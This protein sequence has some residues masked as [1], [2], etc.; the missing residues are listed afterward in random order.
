MKGFEAMEIETIVVDGMEI[1]WF[2]EFS[3]AIVET[4]REDGS[5]PDDYWGDSQLATDWA[6]LT[7]E[8]E[9]ATPVALPINVDIK[10]GSWPNPINPKETGVFSVA[11]CG[12]SDFDITTVNPDEITIG[13]PG[14]KEGV[15]P[16]RW[17]YNDTATPWLGEDGMGHELESDGY[18]DLVLHFDTQEVCL[19]S[20]LG[21]YGGETI[22]LQVQGKLYEWAGGNHIR[23]HDFVRIKALKEKLV[24]AIDL[25]KD[26][27]G[28]YSVAGVEETLLSWGA[29]VYIIDG[30]FTIPEEANVLLIPAPRDSYS[31]YE[32]EVIDDWFSDS[33]DPRLLWV[34]GDS[35]FYPYWNYFTPDVCND[36]LNE[37][38]ANL[39][40]SADTVE[41]YFHNDGLYYR[42]AVQTPVSDG[43]LNRIFTRGV[44]SAIFHGPT[45][46]LGYQDGAVVDLMMGSIEGIELV[47]RSSEDAVYNNWD[48]TTGQ[49]DYYSSN[50]INGSY[51]MLAVQT[52]DEGKYVIA[53]GEVIFSDYM[54][55]Y[56]R[57]TQQLFWNNG[58]H[59]GKLLVDNILY[60]FWHTY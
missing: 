52:L 39:R 41:D 26:I 46:V 42:V 24:V 53:S 20:Y 4:Q 40:I 35:D 32:L 57:L 13:V 28:F 12:T 25:S 7:L 49:F 15:A 10:P 11:I 38:G 54:N 8:R 58:L 23:G 21:I 30:V 59:D 27:A 43:E 5:W 47:M 16:L 1:D 37:V 18:L 9:M 50:N 44:E 56:D 14:T 17:D 6:L 19:A 36:V 3:T 33:K 51:P 60:W 22:R 29:D 55:M 31:S 45:S 2:E 34:A 48:G